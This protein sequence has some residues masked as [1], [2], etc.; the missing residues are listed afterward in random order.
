MPHSGHKVVAMCQRIGLRVQQLNTG[1]NKPGTGSEKPIVDHSSKNRPSSSG[2]IKARAEQSM[3]TP[4]NS[5]RL[6]QKGLLIIVVPLISQL[7][8]CAI[9]WHLWNVPLSEA[10]LVIQRKV[11]LGAATYFILLAAS[12]AFFFYDSIFCEIKKFVK[13][14]RRISEG[15]KQTLEPLRTEEFLTVEKQFQELERALKLAVVAAHEGQESRSAELRLRLNEDRMRLIV[16]TMPVGLMVIDARG[17]VESF[18]PAAQLMFQQE[19]SEL[20]GQP[21]SQL[22]DAGT[23]NAAINFVSDLSLFPPTKPR[24]LTGLRKDGT[25]FPIEL[26]VQ[27]FEAIEGNRFLA[28]LLDVTERHEVERLKQ[29]FV[30]MVSHELRTPLTSVGAFLDMILLGTFDADLQAMKQRSEVAGR[31][32]TRLVELVN[33]L[34]DLEKMQSG[35]FE[36]RVTVVSAD[37]VMQRG[38]DTI[39]EFAEQHDV[40]LR[41]GECP[42][43]FDGDDERLLQVIINLLSNAIKFSNPGETVTIQACEQGEWI[44]FS[45]ED[46]GLGVPAGYEEIIFEKYRQAAQPKGTRHKGTGLGLPLCKAI[47]EQHG[48]TIGVQTE[49]RERGSRF[50]FRIPKV[51]DPALLQAQ[52]RR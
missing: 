5:S 7:I 46:C 30:G 21:F 52:A 13:N 31:N 40:N 50:W 23:T 49:G 36:F 41:K 44:E 28:L 45:V 12:L 15:Q 48:G 10:A 8:F 33:D 6:L 26:T 42:V 29:E 51:V 43:R 2:A 34:L 37:E 14:V 32:V 27:S 1:S 4:T 22:F 47:V 25:T 16:N 38:I 18:N 24:E 19:N 20:S 11:M 9:V 17:N 35:R 39:R 3:A